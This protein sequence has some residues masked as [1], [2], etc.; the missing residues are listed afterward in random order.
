M[1]LPVLS[2]QEPPLPA[3]VLQPPL[4]YRAHSSGLS[5][6]Q[7]FS[8]TRDHVAG[9]T[10]V[11]VGTSGRSRVNSQ[12]AL[13]RSAD[14][15]ATVWENDP[16]QAT[17]RGVNQVT[18]EWPDRVIDTV[19]RAQIESNATTLNITIQLTITMD[20]RPHHQRSWTKSIPR[21]LL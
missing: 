20:G 12:V 5:E 19:A 4:P 6:P 13:Q 1:E 17:I 15:T 14:A 3:P 8:T 10:S 7:I 2:A 18:L 11:R 21:L 9:T 16:A